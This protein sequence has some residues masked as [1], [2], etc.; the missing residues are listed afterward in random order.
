M[1]S[2]RTTVCWTEGGEPFGR[3]ASTHEPCHRVGAKCR[4]DRAGRINRL[5]RDFEQGAG[6][7]SQVLLIRQAAICLAFSTKTSACLI[8]A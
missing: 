7:I 3:E 8:E 5:H 2:Q 4:V 1:P 6:G